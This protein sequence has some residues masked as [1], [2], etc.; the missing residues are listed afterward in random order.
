MLTFAIVIPNFNQSHFL[1]FALESLRYQSAP[2]NLAIMDGGST[3][4]FNE[5]IS[6]Y[7]L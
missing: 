3:D 6:K 4:N 2:F 7:W 1:P 5:V